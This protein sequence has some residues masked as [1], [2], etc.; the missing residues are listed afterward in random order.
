MLKNRYIYTVFTALLIA[1]TGCK[2]TKY[3]PEGKLLLKKNKI[4]VNGKKKDARKLYP[5]LIQRPNSG[6][7]PFK[8]YVYNMHEPDYI[9][10]WDA[11]LFKYRDSTHWFTRTFSYKQARVYVQ[12]RKNLNKWMIENGEP[13]SL[14]SLAKTKKTLTNLKRHFLDMGYFKTGIRYRI[15]TLSEKKGR[16]RYFIETGNPT[17]ID[18]LEVH[19][20]SPVIDSL[21]RVN[22]P[23]SL[24]RT[25]QIY[26][27]ENL[28]KEADRLTRIFR[29]A[30]VY[31]FTRFAI[32]FFEIDTSNNNGRTKVLLDIADRIIDRGDSVRHEPY[33]I[34]KIK[35][36]KLYTDYTFSRK[37]LHPTDS[38]RYKGVDYLA[39]DELLY[40]PKH[41]DNYIFITPGQAYSD[42]SVEL[43]RKHLRDLDNFKS[44]RIS[45]TENEDHSLTA[46]IFLSPQNRYAFKIETEATHENIK[47]FG[48]SG[49]TSLLNRNLMHGG[50]NLKLELQGSFYSSLVN[51]ETTTFGFNAWEWGGYIKY[52][53][54]RF[55]PKIPLWGKVK[56]QMSPLTTFQLGYSSQKNIGLDKQ[57]FTLIY[58]YDWSPG[59]HILHHL[60]VLNAQYIRNL[61][62]GSFFNIYRSER[63][64]LKQIYETYYQGITSFEP[65]YDFLEYVLDDNEFSHSHPEDYTV[66]QN[67]KQRYDIITEDV[68]VPAV[69]YQFTYNTQSRYSDT[70]YSFFKFGITSSGLLATAVIASPEEDTP[71]QL[72][73]INIAQYVKLDT[74]YRRYWNLSLHNVLAFR[75]GLGFALPYGNSEAIPL[76]GVIL[77]VDL[78]TLELGKSMSW[79]P[80]SNIRD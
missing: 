66:A 9:K 68:L 34:M 71:K 72:F 78:M 52:R 11:K 77:P 76:A 69:S 70:D 56:N 4:L 50:E 51:D 10:K 15:D 30:G 45:F 22:L 49:R 44:I 35:E 63:S 21:Y 20:T 16:V 31:H 60:E 67:V 12:F 36:V 57:R 48:L 46:R 41:L 39:F 33:R 19:I 25:G 47:P 55:F 32:G 3:V 29:N 42:E 80:E 24:I 8:L 53:I 74:E 37:D 73:G 1:L 6:L 27:R 54:P 40:K 28:E 2:S 23:E 59:K 13:P 18:T 14:I 38:I 5:Y 43:T 26:R 75:L 79:D 17:Y 64:K 7:I 65:V 58:Q 61:N 62:I